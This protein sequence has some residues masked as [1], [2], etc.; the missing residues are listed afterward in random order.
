MSQVCSNLKVA[1]PTKAQLIAGFKSLNYKAVQTYYDPNLWKT[2]APPEVWY[3][4]FKSFKKHHYEQD[5][6]HNVGEN[7]VA[8]KI[9]TREIVHEPSFEVDKA[10]SKEENKNLKRKYF[11]ATEP[12]WGPKA[13]ATGG[14]K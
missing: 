12:N 14:K 8:H 11:T 4:I 10:Q 9:L 6:M 5:Y 2:N 7:S 3:D 1:N 13:R